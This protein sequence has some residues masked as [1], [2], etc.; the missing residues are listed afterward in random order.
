MKIDSKS[1]RAKKYHINL[2]LEIEMNFVI[3]EL[4]S[5]CFHLLARELC[6]V[7]SNKF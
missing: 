1:I 4:S 2:M 7:A 5:S 3:P 6:T